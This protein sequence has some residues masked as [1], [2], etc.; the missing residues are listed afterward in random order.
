MN[1][2]QTFANNEFGAVR[3]MMI[4]DVPRFVGR[5]V[6]VALGYSNPR[7]TLGAH[8][9]DEDKNKN[10]VTIRDGIQGGGKNPNMTIIN[11]SGPYSLIFSSKLPRRKALQTPGDE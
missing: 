10:T 11:E 6:A 8:V 1:E 5:D 3:S 7:K 2:L 4:G 9:D